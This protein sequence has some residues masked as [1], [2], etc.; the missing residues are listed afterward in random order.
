MVT[1][2]DFAGSIFEMEADELAQPAR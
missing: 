2:G 1:T